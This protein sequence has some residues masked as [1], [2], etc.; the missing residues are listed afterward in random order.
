LRLGFGTSVL[1][2]FVDT[3]PNDDDIEKVYDVLFAMTDGRW[4]YDY[5]PFPRWPVR[6]SRSLPFPHLLRA[7]WS[8][9]CR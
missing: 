2:D 1:R 8:F 6:S 5:P 4:C 3:C 7:P 9:H